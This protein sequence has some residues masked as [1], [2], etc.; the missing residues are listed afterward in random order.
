[1]DTCRPLRVV[2]SGG[3]KQLSGS[4]KVRPRLQALLV[5]DK[6][7][8]DRATGKHIVAGTFN[9]LLFFKTEAMEKQNEAGEVQFGVPFAG[10]SAGSPFVYLSLTDIRGKQAFN[11]RYVHLDVDRVLFEIQFDVDCKNPLEM[12][13]M[14]IPSPSLPTRTPGTYAFELVWNDEPLGA[15]RIIVQEIQRPGEK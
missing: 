13:E 10:A 9:T 8:A 12:V 7:Y 6:V 4:V 3:A 14:A 11:L 5:A 2:S 15:Y 1:M